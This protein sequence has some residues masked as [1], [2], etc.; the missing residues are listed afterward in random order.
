MEK[1]SE[2]LELAEQ[3]VALAEER[4]LGPYR[5]KIDG[6]QI[7][8][9]RNDD[10]TTKTMSYPKWLVQKNLDI[11]LDDNMTIDHW[12]SN[13]DNNDLDNLKIIDRSEHSKQDTRRVKLVKCKCAWC[14]K[15]FE[16]SP[17]LLRDKASKGKSGPF[18]CRQ[19]SGMYARKLQLGLIEK[20]PAQQP[21]DSE[22]YKQKY[23]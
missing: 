1:H 23:L 17:R 10:G 20:L 14:G 19:H 4:V 11:K 7:V 9:I 18:C 3:F 22:Y 6:R 2:L 5:R 15:E 13:I 12:D 8:I 21:I 16:R